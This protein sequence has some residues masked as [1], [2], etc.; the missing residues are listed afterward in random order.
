MIK[1]EFNYYLE[2]QKELTSKYPERYLVIVGNT[3][4]G[5]YG[6]NEEAYIEAQKKYKL[7]TF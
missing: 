6:S 5:D 4:V 7:G 3:V 2:H 1:N